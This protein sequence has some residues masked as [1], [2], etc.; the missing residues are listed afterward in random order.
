M[1]LSRWLYSLFPFFVYPTLKQYQEI[2]RGCLTVL[3]ASLN[4]TAENKAPTQKDPD[5]YTTL[6]NISIDPI[7]TKDIK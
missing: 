1:N 6:Y 5:Y 3:S 7:L 4:F 2:L